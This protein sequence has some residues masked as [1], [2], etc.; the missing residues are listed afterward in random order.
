MGEPVITN[1]LAV[2]G[3]VGWSQGMR[4]HLCSG[5]T[6]SERSSVLPGP[7][8]TSCP[9]PTTGSS[10]LLAMMNLPGFRPTGFMLNTVPQVK[11]LV[12]Y[13]KHVYRRDRCTGTNTVHSHMETYNCDT[14][15]R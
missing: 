12:S 14:M 6:N 3:R 7:W 5:L 10:G 11:S 2:I 15:I 8:G 9:K 1:T 13:G 4:D